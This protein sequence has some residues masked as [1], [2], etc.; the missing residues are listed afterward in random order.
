MGANADR[1]I[2][3]TRFQHSDS[4]VLSVLGTVFAGKSAKLVLIP[5]KY[6]NYRWMKHIANTKAGFH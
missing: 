1:L 4:K 5:S 2:Y 6:S 3:G